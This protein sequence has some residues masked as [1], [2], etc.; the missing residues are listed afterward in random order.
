VAVLRGRLA[1]FPGR[2]VADGAGAVA[3]NG[4][5]ELYLGRAAAHL[6]LVDEAVADLE[7][8]A[9][10]CADSGAAG[11]EVE[12]RYE[13]AAVLKDR[14][15]PGDLARARALAVW[16]IAQASDIGM[17]PW[18]R[19]ARD[20]LE[21]LDDERGNPL[22]PRERE[23]AVL[24]GQGLTN[25]QIAAR[26]YLSGRTAQNHVQHILTNWTCR[27]AARSPC[28]SLPERE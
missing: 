22:T 8:A 11:F 28:G 7:A 13:L 18:E 2:H 5:V 14:A 10:A 16:V 9:G 24:V 25:R 27:T 12:S 23:V 3:Y 19:R 17:T 1:R 20:L 21:R 15:A 6:G 26:L 4:P